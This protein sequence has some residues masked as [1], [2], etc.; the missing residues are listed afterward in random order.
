M[1]NRYNNYSYFKRFISG[2][3]MLSR[4]N[5]LLFS[6]LC[7]LVFCSSNAMAV[8]KGKG[9]ACLKASEEV[10]RQ[11]SYPDGIRETDQTSKKRARKC[12]QA[13]QKERNACNLKNLKC[14]EYDTEV[15]GETNPCTGR[16]CKAVLSKQ[17]TYE[18]ICQLKKAG[19]AFI[20][21]GACEEET[22]EECTD[23]SRAV[24]G[25]I[26]VTCVRAPC[27][28]P[29]P[30]W[31]SN[32]CEL[33]KAGA[34]QIADEFCSNQ[35]NSDSNPICGQRSSCNGDACTNVMHIP[36]WYANR[37]DLEKDNAN[38]LPPSSCAGK[39]CPVTGPACGEP[40][41]SCNPEPPYTLCAMVMPMPT[42][43]ASKCELLASEATLLSP[44]ACPID[45]CPEVDSGEV[46]GVINPE[47][48]DSTNSTSDIARA[49]K[50]ICSLRPSS[51]GW[52][53]NLCELL[54]AGATQVSND[55]CTQQV[56]SISSM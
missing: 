27:D 48:F 5:F 1:F 54:K 23:K 49:D 18:N 51:I 4:F 38:E 14:N 6:C 40:K 50:Q 41:F 2:F 10:V 53:K 35:C 11:C 34:T 15:C 45:K 8:K 12:A 46:C 22:T 39:T 20:A 33:N 3:I 37:C 21:R 25:R 42:W 26:R 28:Q 16:I 32:V 29:L 24:C 13:K 30:Q 36:Q 31:Y 44:S 47:C 56:Y 43:Y 52:Y 55:Q 19:S 9:L 17:Q 7:V